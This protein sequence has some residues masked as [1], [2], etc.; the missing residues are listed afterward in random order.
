M[1]KSDH[2][3]LIAWHLMM[4]LIVMVMIQANSKRVQQVNIS[5]MGNCDRIDLPA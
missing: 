3:H 4:M 5:A 2:P 1:E